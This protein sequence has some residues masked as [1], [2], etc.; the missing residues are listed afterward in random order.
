[1]AANNFRHAL[2]CAIITLIISYPIIGFNLEAQGISV[3]LTGADTSTV[4]LVLLAAVIVFLF[5][6]FRDQIMGGLKSIPS[7]LPKTQKEPMA[8]NKRAKIESWVL[9]GI[10]VLALFWPFFVSRGAVD[11]ATLVLIYVMLALGLNVVVGLAGL[12]DLGYVAFYAVGAYTFALLS[13]Y[14]GISFWM[15]LPIGACLAALFGLVLGFPVLRLRG[16]YLAIVTL[17]FGEIIRILLN[18]WTAVTGGPNGIGGIPDPTLF[19][20]EFGRRVREEGNTSFHETFGIAYSGEHKVIF[21]YLIALVLAVITALIIRRFMR[22]PVGRAWEA[23]REDEIAARSLGLSRTAVKLSAFTIGA[24]FA[25][26][27]G[28]VFASKQ[29]FISPESFVFLESAIILAIVVLGGMGS[30]L[31]V[32][33]AAIAVTILPELAREFS[34]YRML[35]FGAAMVLMMVW[36]P[37]GLMPM[38]R[39]H[40]ELRRQE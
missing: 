8:E 40:I 31:G 16:D 18:N 21:L 24:F 23:L 5:Q 1:M 37:Q 19:G 35:V 30:Q 20:M 3:T 6:L 28:T 38:R 17:G 34:D 15:A 36:R 13:Q 14:A 26:F 22:M 27:A 25:G 4:I 9:T 32:V 12:L 29:G 7:P 33:L 39:I 10:V 11:L 2:F